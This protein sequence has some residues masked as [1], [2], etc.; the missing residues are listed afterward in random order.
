MEDPGSIFVGRADRIER[1]GSATRVVDLKSGMHQGEPNEGQ[2]RQLLLYAVLV[3]RTT[4][5]W[6]AEIAIE[7]ASGEQFVRSRSNHK[8]PNSRSTRCLRR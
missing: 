3:H 7:N 2:L 1:V 8:M 5:S 6:P 4:G